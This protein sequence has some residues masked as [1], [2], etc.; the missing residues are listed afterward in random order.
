MK[1][2]RKPLT[3][4]LCIQLLFLTA[5]CDYCFHM[6]PP[7]EYT[8]EEWA[9]LSPFLDTPSDRLEDEIYNQANRA[10]LFRL[11]LRNLDKNETDETA[12]RMVAAA[13]SLGFA[14]AYTFNLYKKNKWSS[15]VL[16]QVAIRMGHQ[17]AGH[18]LM[19]DYE[20]FER[21]QKQKVGRTLDRDA[22]QIIAQ[23]HIVQA[24][25]HEINGPEE[26][27]LFIERLIQ[28]G[29][30]AK[31]AETIT[32]QPQPGDEK[33]IQTPMYLATPEGDIPVDWDPRS[34]FYKP[35]AFPPDR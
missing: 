13:A 10:A 4:L 20:F 18:A 21:S 31:A 29:P 35:G 16:L 5:C 27:R 3:L 32:Y 9:E 11:G 34:I 30:L 26:R 14:P 33:P 19:N 17:E 22:D 7:I 28:E 24:Q 25:L 8:D 6:Q 1:L 2:L 12:L 15:L 23:A